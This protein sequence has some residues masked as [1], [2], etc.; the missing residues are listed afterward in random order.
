MKTHAACP[1]P[2]C[3]SDTTCSET[4]DAC[5]ARDSGTRGVAN[6]SQKI[7]TERSIDSKS[8]S[9]IEGSTMRDELADLDRRIAELS[10][11]RRQACAGA[12]VAGASIDLSNLDSLLM[13]A[14]ARKQALLIARRLR[15]RTDTD[16]SR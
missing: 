1:M 3:D 11:L 10:L 4:C 14:H 5:S 7:S 9:E 12:L 13:R 6:T 2:S 8:R 16:E 15:A